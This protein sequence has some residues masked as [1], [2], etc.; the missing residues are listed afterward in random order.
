MRKLLIAA[1]LLTGAALFTGTPAKADL[2]CM[3][4]KLG[5]P[6]VCVAEPITCTLGMGG[7]CIAPCVY[8]APK[9]KVIKKH[10]RRHAVKKMKPKK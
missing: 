2:G 9:P 8:E 4:V 3:C 5:A 6:A 1:A 10:H 7:V